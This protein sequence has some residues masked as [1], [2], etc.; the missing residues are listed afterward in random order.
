MKHGKQLGLHKTNISQSDTGAE[1]FCSLQT[2]MLT[3]A[4]Y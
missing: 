3:Q 4:T 1:L 2:T